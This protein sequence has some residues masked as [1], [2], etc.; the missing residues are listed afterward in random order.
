MKGDAGMKNDAGMSGQAPYQVPF[1]TRLNRLWARPLLRG[2]FH[3]LS[4]VSIHGKENIPAKGP[5]I[6]AINHLSIFDPPFIG[7][8]WPTNWNR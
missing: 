7:S 4:Q 6:A 5:Y 3:L 2:V 1:I 8:F